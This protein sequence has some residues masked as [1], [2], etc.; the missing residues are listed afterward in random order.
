MPY[1]VVLNVFDRRI[2]F[3]SN[4]YEKFKIDDQELIKCIDV[5]PAIFLIALKE[6]KVQVNKN[7]NSMEIEQNICCQQ[8]DQFYSGHDFNELLEYLSPIYAFEI[9]SDSIFNEF[10]DCDLPYVIV[11]L[12]RKYNFLNFNDDLYNKYYEVFSSKY[13]RHFENFFLSYSSTH[14]KH[15]FLEVYRC[16]ESIY[17]LPWA[18][19][20]KKALGVSL[21]AQKVAEVVIDEISFRGREKSALL[22]MLIEY[23]LFVTNSNKLRNLSFFS[24]NHEIELTAD[25]VAACVYS[26]RNQ[27]VHQFHVEHEKQIDDGDYKILIAFMIDVYLHYTESF[28]NEFK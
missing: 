24:S 23:P 25:N 22:R 16:V 14:W 8:D 11:F 1:C 5:E 28:C 17:T 21:T 6:L 15:A 4:I 20:V 27:L 9:C 26:I 13:V 7:Y 10:Y 19:S 18:V 12:I 2:V 3:L